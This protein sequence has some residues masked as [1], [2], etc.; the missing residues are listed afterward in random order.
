[1]GPAAPTTSAVAATPAC[2]EASRLARA[3]QRAA[4]DTYSYGTVDERSVAPYE[5]GSVPWSL[6]GLVGL[7]VGGYALWH[8]ATIPADQAADPAVIR[9][10][11]W[12]WITAGTILVVVG[13]F[14]F[15]Q[16]S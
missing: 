8:G 10:T 3:R 13:I 4:G 16:V 12:R 2:R 7:G 9:R 6:V 5:G 1:M 15:S 11:R 14:A